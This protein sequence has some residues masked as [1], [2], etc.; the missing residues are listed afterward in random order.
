LRTVP[1]IL[2]IILIGLL[3]YLGFNH[4]E[5]PNS[6]LFQ[7]T[8]ETK[9]LIKEV[10]LIPGVRGYFLQ[11]VTYEYQV[12]DSIYVDKFK[13]GQ[14]EGH[15]E[16]GD[17]LLIQYSVRKPSKNKVVGFYRDSEKRNKKPVSVSNKK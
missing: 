15:Q 4:F 9:G 10:K 7:K 2:V 5:F 11:S 12:S 6:F 14:R 16:I 13:A 8:S 1:I 17:H 3:F